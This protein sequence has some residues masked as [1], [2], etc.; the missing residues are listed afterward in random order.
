MTDVTGGF[1][2]GEESLKLA[3]EDGALF[4]AHVG[5]K[6]RCVPIQATAQHAAAE[7]FRPLHHGID[8]G[9]VQELRAKVIG[10]AVEIDGMGAP[11]DP[12]P[13]FQNQHALA[14]RP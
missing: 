3:E 9:G 7:G 12:V 14:C 8:G 6:L 11:A 13:G 4:G 10:V 5:W 1:Q 2:D